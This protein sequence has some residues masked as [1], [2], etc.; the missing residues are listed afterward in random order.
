MPT[1]ATPTNTTRQATLEIAPSAASTYGMH[2]NNNDHTAASLDGWI[3]AAMISLTLVIGGIITR[4]FRKRQNVTHQIDEKKA[5][6]QPPI[7]DPA[8]LPLPLLPVEDEAAENWD[9]ETNDTNNTEN[10]QAKDIARAPED[11]PRFLPEHFTNPDNLNQLI[12]SLDLT[13]IAPQHWLPSHLWQ[14]FELTQSQHTSSGLAPLLY[15]APH[16]LDYIIILCQ[17]L[18]EAAPSSNPSKGD[19]H[20]DEEAQLAAK[21]VLI[22]RSYRLSINPEPVNIYS[23][24]LEAT[25][26][27]FHDTL[28]LYKTAKLEPLTQYQQFI[29]DGIAIFESL[30]ASA[31]AAERQ[32]WLEH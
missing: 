30:A 29:Q 19:E 7:T 12:G 18:S 15:M 13:Q 10:T 11:A 24:A 27:G 26:E 31:N 20:T 4:Q 9:S 14:H 28:L 2:G 22:F 16:N 23:H 3:T 21:L 32:A 25:A 1:N 5:D 6:A 8:M 17:H